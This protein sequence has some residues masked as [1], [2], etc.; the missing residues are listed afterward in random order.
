MKR[1]F[2]LMLSLTV[3]GAIAWI[4]ADI[5]E[6]VHARKETARRIERLPEMEVVS[7]GGAPESLTKPA[8]GGTVVLYFHTA[9]PYCKD[10]IDDHL[11]KSRRFGNARVVLISSEE[12]DV[13]RQ[14]SKMT[15]IDRHDRIIVGQDT[16]GAV[17]RHFGVGRVPATFVYDAGGRLTRRFNGLVRTESVVAALPGPP[18]GRRQVRVE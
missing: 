6:M 4:S 3:L 1:V 15:G 12:L 5:A 18:V 17:A 10:Q 8:D 11:S 2:F 9:C 13:L 14:F 16:S 7:I